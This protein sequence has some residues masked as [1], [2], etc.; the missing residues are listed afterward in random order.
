VLSQDYHLSKKYRIA[1]PGSTTGAVVLSGGHIPSAWYKLHS[2]NVK[3]AITF[4]NPKYRPVEMHAPKRRKEQV[5]FCWVVVNSGAS[6]SCTPRNPV[7]RPLTHPYLPRVIN[8]KLSDRYQ[9][10]GCCVDGW[11]SF[12]DINGGVL[13]ERRVSIPLSSET[14]LVK[15]SAG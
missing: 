14:Q 11:I 3:H 2:G 4:P 9:F 7:S 15:I 10:V 13:G 6:A 8:R 1:D 12:V 5:H